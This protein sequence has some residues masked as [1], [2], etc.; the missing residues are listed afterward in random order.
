MN[1]IALVTCYIGSLPDYFQYFLDSAIL[2]PDID[3]Y[4]FNSHCSKPETSSNVKI[5]PLTLEEFNNLA[6]QKLELS[7]NLTDGYKLCD[8]KPAYGVIFEDYLKCYDFWGHCDIDVIWGRISHFLTEAILHDFD[9]IG[10]KRTNLVG[11]FALY[12]NSGITKDLFRQTDDYKNVF[13]DKDNYYYGFDETCRRWGEYHPLEELRDSSQM[14]SI[15]DIAM[16]LEA[17][18]K[19]K[20]YRQNLMREYPDPFCFTYR[21]GRFTDLLND[22][23]EFMYFH[24]VHL[25]GNWKFFIPQMTRLPSEFAVVSGGIIPG[26]TS[27]FLVVFRWKIAKM[28][29][30]IEHCSWRVKEI[31]NRLIARA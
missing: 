17:K 12:R 5:I 28:L 24:L 15:S 11:H 20:V 21:D 23:E 8:L 6:S 29:I 4:I 22:S 31:L 26:A 7:I 13:I 30:A 25:K 9:V 19:L 16:D 18:Q 27:N 3:F 2:N 10:T 1:R 14:V